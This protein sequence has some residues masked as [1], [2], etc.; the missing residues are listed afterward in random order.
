MPALFEWLG[1]EAQ[2]DRTEVIGPAGLAALRETLGGPLRLSWAGGEREWAP[3]CEDITV[4]RDPANTITLALPQ[5]SRVHLRIESRGP[6]W[7]VHDQ[8]TNGTRVCNDGESGMLLQR[9]PCRL[10]RAGHLELAPAMTQPGQA[11]IR[12]RIG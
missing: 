10:G 4:G 3:G 12:F 5:V 1:G 6:Y 7:L 9:E 8:S 2:A 11:R